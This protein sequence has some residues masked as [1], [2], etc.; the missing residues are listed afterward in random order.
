MKQAL[1]YIKK[2]GL[3]AGAGLIAVAGVPASWYF[4]SEALAALRTE[5]QKKVD[6]A[7]KDLTSARLAYK[8]EPMGA[9]ATAKEYSEAPNSALIAQT[10]KIREVM[11]QSSKKVFGEAV[12]FNRGPR[13]GP[14][15]A[16]AAKATLLIPALFPD[17]G[18][19]S[20][21]L[22]LAMARAY[23]TKAHQDLLTKY[24]AGPG[25]DNEV[26]AQELELKKQEALQ[27]TLAP[28]QELKD[29]TAD[30]TETIR[31]AM[32]SHRIRKYRDNAGAY[33]FFADM[34]TFIGVAPNLGE[35][36]PSLRQSWDWQTQLWIREDIFRAAALANSSA[37]SLVDGVVKRIQFIQIDPL[38]QPAAAA[39]PGAAPVDAGAADPSAVPPAN[40]KL[41]ASGRVSGPGSGN[42]MYDLRSCNIVAVV[43][44]KGLPQFLD[45]LA[46]TNFMTVLDCDFDAIDPVEDLKAGFYYGNDAVVRVRLRVETAWLR[47]WTK[48]Y[49]PADFRLEIGIAPD[50]PVDP[51][52]AAAPGG[53]PTPPPA[54]GSSGGPTPRPPNG[55]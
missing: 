32:L 43:S 23:A 45:A 34:D 27:A 7:N 44:A 35:A 15:D 51:A 18:A 52:A 21:V 4:S 13:N 16:A 17:P 50:A 30:Q 2:Y 26:M 10:K 41:S 37:T 3:L 28:G 19:Q 1:P 54:P 24:R 14:D 11:A 12:A 46:R 39:A 53:S 55:G 8:L 48:K 40:L 25:V 22:R 47:E 38:A 29:I 36:E 9:G 31:A 33:K 6:D 42:G 20:Q 49:M 5:Q